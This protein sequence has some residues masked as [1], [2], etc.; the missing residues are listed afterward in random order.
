LNVLEIWYPNEFELIVEL[1]KARDTKDFANFIKQVEEEPEYIEHLLGYGVVNLIDGKPNISIFVMNKELLKE[2]DKPI[3]L[4]K[5]EGTIPEDKIDDVY[6]TISKRR[7]KIERK[8]RNLIKFCLRA[9]YGKNCMDELLKSIPTDRKTGLSRLGYDKVWEELYLKDLIQLVDKNYPI[10]QK[11]FSRDKN[12]VMIWLKY[13]ND[14]RIDAH[15][16]SI[17][18]DQLL[19][20]YTFFDRL[21][22]V[23]ADI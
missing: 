9:T 20:L 7:N 21:D 11:W 6:G 2:Y 3:D 13:L 23:L 17:T 4:S 15:A 1:A 18:K 12:D 16:R 14:F 5:I 19:Y 8:L 22:E 10:L